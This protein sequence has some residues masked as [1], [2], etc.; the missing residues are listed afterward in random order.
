MYALIVVTFFLSFWLDLLPDFK[1]ISLLSQLSDYYPDVVKCL[2]KNTQD[3]NIRNGMAQYWL[4]KYV[5]MLS[6]NNLHVVQ[7]RQVGQGLFLD[8]WVNNLNWYN[9]DFE[10]IITKEIPGSM[11]SIY[12]SSMIGEFG[13]PAD[14]F[15]CEDA[16]VLVYNRKEDT[17]FQKQFKKFFFF[18]FYASDLPSETGKV[19][20]LSRIAS[21]ESS[22]KG[23]LTYGPYVNLLIG[24]YVFEIYYYAKKHN[25]QNVGKWDIMIHPTNKIE[26][27]EKIGKGII[28][29]EGKNII[30]GI[31]K[32]REDAKTEIRTY[33]EGRGILRVD[34]ITIKRIR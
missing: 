26:D 28:E 14:I 5:T 7:V 3:R 16:K 30:S 24:D 29:N 18:D 6:K 13:N 15:L 19:I 10:F 23:Y 22:E 33:Y 21:E 4:A 12:E 9:N 17:N 20:G 31:F 27:K 32:I 2:D 34:K 1:K 25:D 11:R 8:H